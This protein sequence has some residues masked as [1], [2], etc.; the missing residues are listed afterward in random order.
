MTFNKKNVNIKKNVS[1]Y[2]VLG[3]VYLNI[4]NDLLNIKHFC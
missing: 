2:N 4:I 1:A 3:I